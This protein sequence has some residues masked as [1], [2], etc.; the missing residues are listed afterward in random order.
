MCI[1]LSVS[2]LFGLITN[3]DIIYQTSSKLS[4]IKT[5]KHTYTHI[6]FHFCCYRCCCCCNF[7]L[8]ILLFGLYLHKCKTRAIGLN[9]IYTP[10]YIMRVWCFLNSLLVDSWYRLTLKQM[11]FAF[12]F[13]IRSCLISIEIYINKLI[14]FNT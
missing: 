13:F 5:N 12:L 8:I 14:I 3:L 6:N 2:S 11:I 7:F 4:W 1:F 9:R 10:R